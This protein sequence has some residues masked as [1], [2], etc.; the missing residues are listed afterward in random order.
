MIQV[1]SPQVEPNTVGGRFPE[2]P[3]S[4]VDVPAAP[5]VAA[6]TGGR[7]A[8]LP[9]LLV[10]VLLG[11]GATN[12]VAGFEDGYAAMQAGNM[13]TAIAELTKAAE[14]NDDRA[15]Y[16]L[17][18]LYIHG[19]GLPQD[20]DQGI[21][22]LKV[23]AGQGD[24]E[25]QVELAQLYQA[26]SGVPQDFEQSAKWYEAA[27]ENGHLG[28]QLSLADLYVLG[29]GVPLDYVQ[30]YKWYEVA[31]AYWGDLVAGPKSLAAEH[32]TPEQ[33][34]EATNA[35]RKLLGDAAP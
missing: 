15:Q 17:G 35:A 16:L 27:A 14:G 6:S 10:G 9:T 5:P 31:S 32:L 26:G 29:R 24:V 21:R 20:V 28:A 18:T 22:W 2:N 33:I 19:V 25:A 11:L 12:S 23:A 34:A 13:S 4:S 7:R 8:I 30:A 1:K 3:S